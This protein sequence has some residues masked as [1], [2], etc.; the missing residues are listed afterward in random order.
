MK[1]QRV[2]VP[3][4]RERVE[5]LHEEIDAVI[6]KHIDDAMTYGVPRVA[7]EQSLLWS[8]VPGRCRCAALKLIENT[9]NPET[10]N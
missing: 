9:T 1:T 3:S 2:F 10:T 4:L 7:I 6:E 5:A 8:K